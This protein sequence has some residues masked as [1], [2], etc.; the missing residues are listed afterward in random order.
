M[1]TQFRR[2]GWHLLRIYARVKFAP[3]R[4]TGLLAPDTSLGIYGTPEDTKAQVGKFRT[5]RA[6]G[7]CWV[8]RGYFPLSTSFRDPRCG[9]WSYLESDGPETYDVTELYQRTSRISNRRSWI[10][11][12]LLLITENELPM[13]D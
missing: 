7:R 9:V 11:R 2:H 1:F 5:S 13:V 10:C 12:L 8:R 3:I 6:P 4:F